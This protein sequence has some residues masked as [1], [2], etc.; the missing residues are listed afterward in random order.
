MSVLKFPKVWLPPVQAEEDTYTWGESL[1]KCSDLNISL[2]LAA[3][4]EVEVYLG[5]CQV[6]V[7]LQFFVLCA[8]LQK[9]VYHTLES[10]E[11]TVAP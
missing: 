9:V 2:G 6:E 1:V 5:A 3:E 7:C 4:E 8:C 11:D 10:I